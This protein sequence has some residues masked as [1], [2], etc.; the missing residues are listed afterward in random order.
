[1]A[2]VEIDAKGVCYIDGIEYPAVGFGTYPFK[3]RQCAEAVAAAADAGYRIIDTATFYDNFEPIGQE[4]NRAGRLEFYIISKVWRD[5]QAP[6]SL[7]E[8]LN[9]TLERLQTTYLDAYL[10][11]WPNSQIPIEETLQTLEEFRQKGKIR[12]IGLSNVNSNHVKRALE[13]G[14]PIT[15]VQVEMHPQFCDFDLLKFCDSQGI[16]VQA[17]APLGR[18]RLGSD[19]FLAKLGKKYNKSAAQVALRWII[20][21]G[22]MPLP[23]S[24][25]KKHIQENLDIMDFILS[26][27]DMKQIDERAK[28]GQRERYPSLDEYDFTY[29]ECWPHLNTP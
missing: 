18:G 4:V 14:V 10:L 2:T 28:Q 20:Q 26:A 8:D 17:W 22:C 21:H 12:H 5:K 9:A 27:E 13:V 1:M 25:N 7:V 6:K 16:A 24:K 19:A 29:A 11:H 3:G 23:A 15:W